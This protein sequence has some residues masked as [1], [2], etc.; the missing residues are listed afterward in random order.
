MKKPP[1][2][3]EAPPVLDVEVP[4]DKLIAP[5]APP[6]EDSEDTNTSLPEL[7]LS[8]LTS[9]E[10]ASTVPKTLIYV[11]KIRLTLL[12]PDACKLFGGLSR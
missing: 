9:T 4:D 5:P 8:D 12:S 7:E 6:Y 3:F 1:L 2:T 11:L 10:K